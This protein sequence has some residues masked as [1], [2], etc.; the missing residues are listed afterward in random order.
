MQEREEHFEPRSEEEALLSR[1]DPAAHEYWADRLLAP[2]GVLVPAPP[3]PP[4]ALE[5]RELIPEG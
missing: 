2:E 3:P 1:N 5:V 4:G